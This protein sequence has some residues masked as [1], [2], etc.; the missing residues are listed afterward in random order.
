[1]KTALDRS[2][3][4]KSVPRMPR[5]ARASAPWLLAGG[6]WLIVAPSC[7]YN[8]YP[9]DPTF[10]DDWCRATLRADCEDDRP[11]ACVGRCEH[12]FSFA[13]CSSE[14]RE[15]EG[16]YKSASD[17]EFLCSPVGTSIPRPDTC[18]E[19]RDAWLACEAPE[20]R[21]CVEFCR[22]IYEPGVE[23]L[24][25]ECPELVPDLTCED[26][27]WSGA[28]LDELGR[29]ALMRC[30]V[31]VLTRCEPVSRSQSLKDY[32]EDLIQTGRYDGA[33]GAV[34]EGE[35]AGAGPM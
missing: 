35:S 33:G 34:G 30:Y 3:R 25:R 5:P 17:D 14:L 10:C 32:C 8:S 6:M 9:L 31:D 24:K 18:S 4:L 2:S 11:E 29:E 23:H 22:P 28:G 20:V 15:L 16:C 21:A 19:A 13:R 12:G 27:C 1:M 7:D 26:L